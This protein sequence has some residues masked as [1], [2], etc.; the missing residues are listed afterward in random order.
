ME[1]DI[2]VSAAA[3][4]A[5]PAISS[6]GNGAPWMLTVAVG[7]TVKLGNSLTAA[8]SPVTAA[9]AASSSVNCRRPPQSAPP[10]TSATIP[11]TAAQPS[12]LMAKL[13]PPASHALLRAPLPYPHA[14]APCA[15][16]NPTHRRRSFFPR[17]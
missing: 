13:P 3:G 6:V 16:A 2:F 7:T 15:G 4:N 9:A 12:Y 10:Q 5:A 14:A 1:R 11:T 8:A 17:R